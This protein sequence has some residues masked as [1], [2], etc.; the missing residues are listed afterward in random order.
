MGEHEDRQ[1]DRPT[2]ILKSMILIEIQYLKDRIAGLER[3]VRD[4]EWKQSGSHKGVG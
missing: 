1:N 2:Q 4:M 3:T